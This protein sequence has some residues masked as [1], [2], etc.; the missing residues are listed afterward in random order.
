VKVSSDLGHGRRLS[1]E[2]YNRKIVA[3]YTDQPAA[4]AE[5]QEEWLRRQELELTIDHRLG[6]EFPRA[7]REMLWAIQQRVEKKRWR[8]LLRHLVRRLYPS[9]VAHAASGLAG[10]LVAEYAKV[11]TRQ[12]LESF[13]GEVEAHDPALPDNSGFE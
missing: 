9:G 7:R 8:L 3:L 11:L 10:F 13:F 6:V 12:E 4:P 5:Q 1:D 2:E